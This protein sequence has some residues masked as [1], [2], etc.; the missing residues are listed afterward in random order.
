[1]GNITMRVLVLGAAALTGLVTGC[2]ARPP[3][4]VS[5]TSEQDPGRYEKALRATQAKAEKDREDER[6]A[7]QRLRRTPPQ[8]TN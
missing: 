3:A 2:G 5:P 8:T 1:M 6:K 7:F 4:P